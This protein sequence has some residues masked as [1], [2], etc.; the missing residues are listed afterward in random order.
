MANPTDAQL[1]E[2][3]ETLTGSPAKPKDKMGSRLAYIAELLADAGSLPHE[4]FLLW[5][6][7]S[8]KVEQQVIGEALTVGRKTGGGGLSLAEDAHLSRNHFSIRIAAESAMLEDLNSHNGTGVNVPE[9]RVQKQ[10]LRD[11]DCIF[12]GEHIFVFLDPRKVD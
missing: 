12:A 10:V 3:S 2:A 11:G 5:R 4:P 1:R 9:A 6:E 7:P 8:R